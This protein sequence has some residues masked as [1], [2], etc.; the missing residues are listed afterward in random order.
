MNIPFYM[1]KPTA[2]VLLKQSR[3]YTEARRAAKAEA[4]EIAAV[5]A[6][7]ERIGWTAEAAQELAV[8]HVR[9]MQS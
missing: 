7:F 8:I 5:R 9:G 6:Q 2:A 4:Q 3:E 1:D